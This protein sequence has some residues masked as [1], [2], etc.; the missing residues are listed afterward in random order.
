MWPKSWIAGKENALREL[1]EWSGATAQ[2]WEYSVSHSQLLI[3]LHREGSGGI[4]SLFV[5]L[6]CCERVSFENTW[7]DANIAIEESSGK[8]GPAFTVTDADRLSVVAS[9]VFVTRLEHYGIRLRD[10]IEEN[11]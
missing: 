4:G 2:A 6:K 5:L 10:Q 7:A 9:V 11:A 8:Y 1:Q 3:R